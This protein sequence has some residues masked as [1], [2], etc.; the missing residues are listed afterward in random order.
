MFPSLEMNR[1]PLLSSTPEIKSEMCVLFVLNKILQL[2]D[3]FCDGCSDPGKNHITDPT[4]LRSHYSTTS[5][6]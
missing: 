5:R 2:T 6:F 1:K 3:Q 4:Q